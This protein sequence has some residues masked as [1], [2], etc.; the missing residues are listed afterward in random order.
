MVAVLRELATRAVSAVELAEM[1]RALRSR[2]VRLPGH[3]DAIDTCGTGGSGLDRINTSTLAAFIVA[4]E[5]IKVAKHGNKA[6]GGRCG[7]F[8]VLEAVGCRI[9]LGPEHVGRTLD[10]LGIGFMFA[11]LY[12]PAM[13][14]V[15]GVRKSLGIRTVF[16]LL[17]PLASPAFVRRQVLGVP[18][19]KTAELMVEVLRLLRLERALVVCGSDGL[20]EVTLTGPTTVFVLEAGC[21][22]RLEVNPENFG[23]KKFSA[24]VLAGG[25]VK[26][27]VRDFLRIL[28][29]EET[30]PKQDLVLANAA[31]G[32]FLVKRFDCIK[33]GVI[34]A[35]ESL[36]S[37]RAYAFFERYRDLTHAL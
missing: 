8:D 7:S 30:G 32:F 26:E 24:G 13:A 37:G 3:E 34:L 18:D 21:V 2:A 11:R 22:E 9:D 14:H 31:A 20:D 23:L 15:A 17:G 5:G 29:G 10:E 28:K 12:H 19:E 1:A 35:R 33:D 6:A 27:N 16:N 36:E 4:A 25:G